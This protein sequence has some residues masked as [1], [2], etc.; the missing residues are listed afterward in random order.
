MNPLR[1]IDTDALFKQADGKIFANMGAA[2][3]L[4]DFLA[5]Y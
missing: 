2:S 5:G 3:Y 1:F 4:F